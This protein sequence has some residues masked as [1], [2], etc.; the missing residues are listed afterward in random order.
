M[1]WLVFG[2]ETRSNRIVV[3]DEL[4]LRSL[5]NVIIGEAVAGN[6]SL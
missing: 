6:Q 2:E 3:R 4:T 1:R 5:G